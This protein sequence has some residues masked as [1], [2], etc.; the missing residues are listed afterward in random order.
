MYMNQEIWSTL[1]HDKYMYHQKKTNGGNSRVFD[2]FVI[3]SLQVYF[4]LPGTAINQI[5]K[6]FGWKF[7]PPIHFAN[8]CILSY[9][10]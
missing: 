3:N 1:L 7:L 4:L 6:G 5:S 9:L 8:Q 2:L 10:Q